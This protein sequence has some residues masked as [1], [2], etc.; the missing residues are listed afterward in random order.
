MSFTTTFPRPPDTGQRRICRTARLRSRMCG[1]DTVAVSADGALDAANAET[2]AQYLRRARQPGRNLIVDLAEIRFLGVEAGS[3]LIDLRDEFDD[4]AAR[5]GVVASPAVR[6]TL[7]VCDPEGTI[8]TAASLER[9][10]EL[11]HRGAEPPFALL[12]R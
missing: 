12:G 1:A 11:V 7:R 5:W 10:L 4:A 2:F 9:A 8:A 6:R 3:T